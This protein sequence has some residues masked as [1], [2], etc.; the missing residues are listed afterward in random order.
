MRFFRLTPNPLH[1]DSAAWQR[2]REQRE[3]CVAACCEA[4]ARHAASLLLQAEGVP[5]GPED[6]AT[7]WD[8]PGLVTCAMLPET[9]AF[10][11]DPRLTEAQRALL[12]QGRPTEV[13]ALASP[14][15]ANPS[16]LS[17]EAAEAKLVQA[18]AAVAEAFRSVGQPAAG[19]RMLASVAH[20]WSE[21]APA[22]PAAVGSLQAPRRATR[23]RRVERS[24]EP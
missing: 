13:P 14:E 6:A 9:P 11:T 8:L 5:T 20:A 17:S 19:Q 15:D 2:S 4:G 3:C 12:R 16:A 21:V 24:P 23:A 7:P 10:T 1:L 22:A 18:L